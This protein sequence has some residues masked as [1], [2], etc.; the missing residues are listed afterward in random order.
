MYV[1]SVI[2]QLSFT[3]DTVIQIID[4]LSDDDLN[5]RPM[6]NKRSIGE[7]VQ[8][9]CELMAAD[10]FI[11]NSATKKEMDTFYESVKCHTIVELKTLLLRGREQLI[12]TYNLYNEE[13]LM[14]KKSS[15]WGVEY[16]RFEWLLEILVHFT[17]HRA[18]LH[19][20]VVLK[21]GDMR[22]SLFE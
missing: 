14:Q 11:S 22:V 8:H 6:A 16:T 3:V 13:E 21:N 10:L 1:E 18:Q 2:H 9:L 15:Y 5:D 20:L 7:I 19:T 17:H 4:C 12:N